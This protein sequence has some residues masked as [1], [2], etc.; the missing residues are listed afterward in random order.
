MIDKSY[1]AVRTTDSMTEF[2]RRDETNL[3]LHVNEIEN[4]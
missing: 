4:S 2:M 3:P 1:I